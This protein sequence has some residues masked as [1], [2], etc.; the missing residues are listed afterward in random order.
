VASPLRL[1]PLLGRLSSRQLAWL[2]G[3]LFLLNLVVPDPLPFV[4]EALLG[5]LTL[6]LS[7][8]KP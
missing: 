8:Q 5:L 3:I 2:A 6:W 1:L 7:R 4:D